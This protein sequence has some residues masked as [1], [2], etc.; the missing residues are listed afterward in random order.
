MKSR[1][2]RRTFALFAEKQIRPGHFS[3]SGNTL[4]VTGPAIGLDPPPGNLLANAG[5]PPLL[6]THGQ[7]VFT[8]DDQGNITS[9]QKVTGT[10]QDVCELL[11]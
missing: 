5:L 10:V 3:L 4:V 2:F 6:L 9:I 8:L 7:L 11:Q 1:T